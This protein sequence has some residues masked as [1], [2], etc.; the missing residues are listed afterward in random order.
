MPLVPD[1]IASHAVVTELPTGETI[2]NPVITTLLLATLVLQIDKKK[3]VLR[4]LL[5][6]IKIIITSSL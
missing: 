3:A 2:P 4:P 5:I 1:L 6:F